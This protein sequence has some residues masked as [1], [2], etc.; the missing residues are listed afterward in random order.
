MNFLRRLVL[1]SKHW[2]VKQKLIKQE[3]LKKA[4]AKIIHVLYDLPVFF[5]Y[6]DA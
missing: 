4:Q 5:I 3:K 1:D 2:N 6:D